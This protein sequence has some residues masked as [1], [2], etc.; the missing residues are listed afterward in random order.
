MGSG[1]WSSYWRVGHDDVV[2]QCANDLHFAC[3]LPLTRPN[4]PFR[5][6][7]PVGNVWISIGVEE[8][9]SAPLSE[10][11]DRAHFLG[12]VCVVPLEPAGQERRDCVEEH[13]FERCRRSD[14]CRHNHAKWIADW[15]LALEGR[16]HWIV[17]GYDARDEI[18]ELV[19]RCDLVLQ[20]VRAGG[21]CDP[22]NHEIS[23]GSRAASAR[24]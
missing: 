4:E 17:G 14:V 22:L 24:E 11:V 7:E 21:H 20:L 6:A 18:G 1:E 23:T 16:Q 12:A 3:W 10:L 2:L 5:N 8:R 19:G 13:R 15:V 9:S